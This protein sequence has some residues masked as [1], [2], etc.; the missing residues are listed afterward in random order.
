M[1]DI[2]YETLTKGH[3]TSKGVIPHVENNCFSLVF[4]RIL[5]WSKL[6][7]GKLYTLTL[8]SLKTNSNIGEYLRS[9]ILYLGWKETIHTCN[10]HGSAF[11]LKK[12]LCHT[13]NT[14][15]V[16][17]NTTH[18]SIHTCLLYNIYVYI[19]IYIHT[20]THRHTHT[21]IVD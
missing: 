9:D 13:I 15:K 18:K 10:H 12:K 20:H 1:Q 11:I 2:W 6:L 3:W 17:S 8:P 16:F 21:Y 7:W 4:S 14:I 19:C 5:L